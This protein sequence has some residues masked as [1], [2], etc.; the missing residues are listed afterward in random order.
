M[1]EIYLI[2]LTLKSMF[3][4][5]LCIL[6]VNTFA[7]IRLLQL[8]AFKDHKISWENKVECK[9]NHVIFRWII[10]WSFFKNIFLFFFIR[11]VSYLQGDSYIKWRRVQIFTASNEAAC[12]SLFN[13]GS[14]YVKTGIHVTQLLHYFNPPLSIITNYLSKKVGIY[15][16]DINNTMTCHLYSSVFQY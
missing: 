2:P 8:E 10:Y 12:G 5:Y 14:E 6:H 1:K 4:N 7:V 16:N 13:I 15:P 11:T 9:Y 3:G